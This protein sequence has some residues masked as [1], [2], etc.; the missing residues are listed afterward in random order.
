MSNK[1][2]NKIF[3]TEI[4]NILSVSLIELKITERPSSEESL[5][6]KVSKVC[7]QTDRFNQD[8]HHNVYFHLPFGDKYSN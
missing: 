6:L 2:N 1:E 8:M 3:T 4:K 7:I 5:L